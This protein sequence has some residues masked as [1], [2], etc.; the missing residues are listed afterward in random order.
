MLIVVVIFGVLA[1]IATPSF[2][3]F[4]ASQRVQLAAT[5]LFTALLRT[6]GEAIKQNTD[7]TLSPVGTW[8]GGW[9]VTAS[10]QTI[11]AHGAT[12]NLSIV[13]CAPDPVTYRSSGRISGTETPR[14]SISAT[15]TSTARCVQVNLS[16]EPV[17]TQLACACP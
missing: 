4:I 16:G 12:A 17:V 5:D 10:G 1:V 3:E 13:T 11:E 15:Q 7:S 8:T 9:I 14:F 6:R 2:S